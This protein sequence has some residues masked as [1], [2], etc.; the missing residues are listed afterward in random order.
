MNVKYLN[1]N[2]EVEKHLPSGTD[3]ARILAVVL[4]LACSIRAPMPSSSVEDANSHYRSHVALGVQS[5]LSGFNENAIFDLSYAMNQSRVFWLLRYR[6]AH[7]NPVAVFD[8]QCSL[9]ENLCGVALHVSDE[10]C[11]FANTYKREIARML[12]MACNTIAE[13]TSSVA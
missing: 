2:Q 10:D 3:R 9:Y 13:V 11:A 12:P 6:A 8:P 4:A 5:I 1:F 7:P